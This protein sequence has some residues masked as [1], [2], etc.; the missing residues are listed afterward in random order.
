[1]IGIAKNRGAV[2]ASTDEIRQHYTRVNEYSTQF[3]ASQ[4]EA[5]RNP[6][7]ARVSFLRG[8]FNLCCIPREHLDDLGPLTLGVF[9]DFA[10]AEAWLQIPVNSSFEMLE[11]LRNIILARYAKVISEQLQE[12]MHASE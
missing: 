7:F 1:M 4:P 10:T 9:L 11:S 6:L 8:V 2:S 5:P 12:S 3:F